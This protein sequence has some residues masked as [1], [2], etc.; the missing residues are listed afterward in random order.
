MSSRTAAELREALAHLE[1][2]HSVELENLLTRHQ[3]QLETLA[4]CQ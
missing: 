3:R 4:L 1:H 2:A